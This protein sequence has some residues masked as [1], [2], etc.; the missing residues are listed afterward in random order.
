[1]SRTVTVVFAMMVCT[2]GLAQVQNRLYQHNPV[3]QSPAD[4]NLPNYLYYTPDYQALTFTIHQVLPDEPFQFEAAR[5]TGLVYLGPGDIGLITAD[6]DVGTVTITV[7]PQV[8]NDPTRP[9]G[10]QDIGAIDFSAMGVNGVVQTLQIGGAL[11]ALSTTD[12]TVYQIDGPFSVLD[13]ARPLHV[14]SALLDTL[15]IR[16]TADHVGDLQIGHFEDLAHLVVTGNML[17][18]IELG[19]EY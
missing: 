4:P 11:G 17:G 13:V 10:A 15:T 6:E 5:W 16:G 14:T 7:V 2:A 3:Y 9:F 19:D 8:N 12:S 1:M 18:L